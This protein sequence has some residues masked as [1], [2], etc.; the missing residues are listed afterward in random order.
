VQLTVNLSLLCETPTFG[1]NDSIAVQTKNG[2][3]ATTYGRG[4]IA[5]SR[6]K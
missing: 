4:S 6:G 2:L 5:K 3:I 1:G